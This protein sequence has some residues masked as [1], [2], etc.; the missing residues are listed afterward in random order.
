MFVA[1]CLSARRW[2]L[3]DGPARC[4][5]PGWGLG[6]ICVVL[7]PSAVALSQ[8]E[9]AADPTPTAADQRFFE[10][11]I[12]P[13]LVEH[14]QG[15]H[16]VKK[17]QNGLR[18]DSRA[19]VLKGGDSGPAALSRDP[20]NSLLLRAVGY[21]DSLK[22][23]PRG[24]LPATAVAQ[25]RDWVVRG[26]PWGQDAPP[27]PAPGVAEARSHWAFQPLHRPPVP[28]GEGLRE[29]A[30]ADRAIDSF[31]G[32]RLQQAGLTPAPPADRRTLIRRASFD[33]LGLPPEPEQVARFQA[34][35]RPTATAFAQVVDELLQ[36]PHYGERWGRHWLDLARY[37]DNKGYVF[38]EEQTH[39]WGYTY[40]DWVIRAFNEDLPYN[41]FV[42]AQ[43]AADQLPPAERDRHLPALGFITIGGHFVNNIHDIFDDR[44]DVV[45]RG[46]MGL[47][48]TCARCHD[49]KFDPIP[50]SDYYAL[51]GVF[52]SSSEPLV[53]PRLAGPVP[54]TE[55]F[56]F[57][58]QELA[59]RYQR[60]QAFLR[61]KHQAL[62]SGGRQRF[63]EYLLAAHASRD[64]PSTED[65]MLLIPEG[66]LHPTVVQRYWL[67]L[68]KTRR[69]SDPFWRIWHTLAALPTDDFPRQAA[70]ALEALRQPAEGLP[71]VNSLAL[72]AVTQPV[73]ATLAEVAQRLGE[74][75][76]SLDTRWQQSLAPAGAAA[77]L[78]PAGFPEPEAEALRQW[79]YGPEAPANMP[80][81]TGWGVLTLLPDRAAQGEYQRLLKE[82][83]NW[84]I[85][86]PNAPPR[87][88]VL[89][90]AAEPYSPRVFQRGN[91]NRPG[92]AVDRRFLSLLSINPPPVFQRGSGRWE[93]A[94]QI[95]S[96]VNPLTPR[97]L[98]NRVWQHHFGVGLVKTPSDFGVR[99]EPPS[100]P[101]LLDWLAATFVEQGWSLKRLHRLILASDTWQRSSTASD[102]DHRE[103]AQRVDPENRWLWRAN[104]QRHDFETLRDSLYWAAGTLDRS[105]GGP[106]VPLL[107][108]PPRRSVYGFID[109]L[110]LPGLLRTFD[111]PSPD[112]SSA[113]RDNTTVAPQA[114]F[115]MN[116]PLVTEAARLLVN[117]P[118]IQGATAG[119]DRVAALIQR[120]F[121]RQP[122]AAE[123]DL[124]RQFFGD[125]PAVLQDPEAWQTFGQGLLLT[126]EFVFS[127]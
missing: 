19:F 27:T 116:G 23:P 30:S 127:D 59:N 114:L 118:E 84:M 20:D 18:L 15:C 45:T 91:P 99:S 113:Q 78:T 110:A 61:Q 115:L 41:Q 65:F 111:F 37:A 11:Q 53:P 51:Y 62:T 92:E 6:A 39:P 8:P 17:Q 60:L 106:S 13:L 77:S 9:T 125:D 81:N 69:S 36:S 121:A 12:R 76:K 48:V 107:G 26:L 72:A 56:E 43:L 79:L 54:E 68:Q 66:D 16:G 3:H 101:E 104:R 40:R 52:R 33:L 123:Q 22:M 120:L 100:H 119:P 122:T 98:V 42:V 55:E 1:V 86:S 124:A 7:A 102:A 70:A 80:Y 108:G 24:P 5:V 82:L 75:L 44:I 94:Q 97:V 117:R 64:Q 4:R 14:C 49:H 95:V 50:Q 83:E 74:L 32:Q 2:L 28:P 63:A 47:T 35:P 85:R 46:L 29:P 126:N 71:P 105:V 58:E 96:P 89:E 103:R 38:F 87:A 67:T 88:M 90:E 21:H 93:L 10:E 31:I 57:F 112:S 34:D 109:R 73:P 25:L